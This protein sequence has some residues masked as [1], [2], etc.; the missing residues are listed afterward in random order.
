MS[1]ASPVIERGTAASRIAGFGVAII[2]LLLAVAPQ[3]LSAG[4]VDR[5]TALFIYV[6]LAAMWNALAGFGGLV[7]VGQQVFFGLGAYF[8]IRLANAG[9]NPFVSL[10]VSA[11]IVGAVSWPISLFM[12][13]LRNGEFAIGM[14]VIAALTHLLVNLDRL[15]QG[16]TGTSL[17]SLNVYDASTRRVAIYWL[18]LA[19]MTALLAILFGL[20]RGSTGAAIRAIRDNE[21]AAASIGV[22]VTGTKRVLFVL[23]AFGIGIAGALWLATA[24]T[25]QPKTYF[26]VQWTA[27]MIFMVLVGGIG[28]FEGAILGALLFFLIE[29]WFGGTGVW[30]L[31]GLGATALAFSLLLPRGLWGTL[32]ERFGWRLL[33]VGYRVRLPVNAS[34]T[35]GGTASPAQVTTSRE[36]A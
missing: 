5:M 25:F 9:L 2:I 28:T 4:A 26:S 30:Y 36:K 33:S 16:E 29:T 27:Y 22:R 34:D 18:A 21:D 23:A 11:V 7:S 13:R 20:L 3:F 14:W 17:I 19:S 8:A 12:L 6:I 31:I 1:A 10:F 35:T 15:I 32:E 24:I